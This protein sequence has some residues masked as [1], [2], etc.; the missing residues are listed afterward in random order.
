MKVKTVLIISGETSGDLH[1][2]NLAFALRKMRPELRLLGVGGPR[3]SAAG[4]ELIEDNREMGVIGVWEVLSHLKAIRRAY[5]RVLQVLASGQ[6]DLLVLIDYP[7][8]NFRVAHVAHRKKIPIVYY[9][10]PQI[11][12]WRSGRVKTVKKLVQQM[13]VILP[14][15]KELYQQSGV[16]C[17]FVGHPLLDEVQTDLDKK[18]VLRS[19]RLDPGQPV[20]GLLP[21]SRSKEVKK[22]LPLML[23]AMTRIGQKVPGIQL[24]LALAPSIEKDEVLAITSRWP[25]D[26]RI[27]EGK[28]DHVIAASD[29]VLVASGTATLQAA[30][31]ETPMVILYRV[32]WLTYLL[33]RILIKVDH[34]G[35]VNLVAGRRIVPEL[36]Q[37]EAT[38]ERIAEEI[39]GMLMDLPRREA[40]KKEL[41]QVRSRLGTPGAS[42]RAAEIILRH[43]A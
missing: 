39:Q 18:E 5:R 40:I 11:W 2:G 9:I 3:M 16:P 15:E 8:F 6:V 21:G 22:I 27:I 23:A 7:E 24:L 28:T 41:A 36:L 35:L 42:Q 10:S 19:F 14:F 31:L 33:G 25:L 37:S 43:I 30:I 17:E 13:I 29:L 34:I 26:I 12:A 1:G 38:P 4:V 20:I 32:A